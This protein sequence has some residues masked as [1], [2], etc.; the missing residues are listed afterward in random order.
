MTE[1]TATALLHAAEAE[2][3]DRGIGEA[4]LRA[5]MRAARTDPGSIHYHFGSREALA[6]AVLDRI[7]APLNA[8]RLELL[9]RAPVPISLPALVDALIRPDIEAATELHRRG[10]GRARLIG[11]VYLQPTEFVTEL[12]E[13]H[14]RPVAD[15]FMPHLVRA[16]PSVPPDV[17]AWR[18]RWSVFGLL[19]ALLSDQ[20]GALDLGTDIEPLIAQITATAAG[21]VAA[22]LPPQEEIQ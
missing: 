10:E 22:P 4:S 16:V 12:V 21:A 18:I 9:D 11:A 20:T 19:G 13:G 7:L 3:A 17:L 2:F 15:R 6:A 1:S 5:I 8:R 14:F